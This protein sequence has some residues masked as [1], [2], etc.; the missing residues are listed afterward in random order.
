MYLENVK[1]RTQI[2]IAEGNEVLLYVTVLPIALFIIQ[3]YQ[4]IFI[5]T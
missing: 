5:P 1:L 2:F 4:R 3:I